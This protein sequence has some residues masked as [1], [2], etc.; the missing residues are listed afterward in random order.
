MAKT[1]HP[2]T[3]PV[4]TQ[5]GALTDPAVALPHE[6][7]Y[8]VRALET[9][10]QSADTPLAERKV[11]FIRCA[12]ASLVLPPEKEVE[13][14]NFKTRLYLGRWEVLSPS[15]LMYGGEHPTWERVL[16]TQNYTLR[17]DSGQRRN[18]EGIAQ[19]LDRDL[20]Y[21]IK[22]AIDEYIGRWHQAAA[23]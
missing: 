6:P 23:N 1:P 17:L 12:D 14:R 22:Q 19:Q 16:P 15:D 21:V 4:V 10:W 13:F 11:Y 20:S 3:V 8:V 2:N 18:L 5:G 9:P 7:G